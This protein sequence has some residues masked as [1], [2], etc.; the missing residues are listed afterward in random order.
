MKDLLNRTLN[1]Y[2]IVIFIPFYAR[3]NNMKYGIVIDSERIYID[4]GIIKEKNVY[5]INP[6]EEEEIIRRNMITSYLIYKEKPDIES[7]EVG[8]LYRGETERCTYLYLGN[9]RL[10]LDIVTERDYFCKIPT[11]KYNRNSNLFIKLDSNISVDREFLTSLLKCGRINMD[12]FTWWNL[13]D[14]D[15]ALCFIVSDRGTKMTRQIGKIK[16]DNLY[17]GKKFLC[18]YY[19]VTFLS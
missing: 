4:T 12:E 8:G 19:N 2:D 16:V 1:Q 5:K 11:R 18:N 9:Y 13:Q 15:G 6:T 17:S 3:L 7:Y 10:S 14:Y